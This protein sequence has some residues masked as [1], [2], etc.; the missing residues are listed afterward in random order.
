MDKKK[1]TPWFISLSL[2]IRIIAIIVAFWDFNY[3]QGAVYQ[4]DA[5]ESI[6]LTIALAGFSIRKAAKKILGNYF[7]NGINS[8]RNHKL[9]KH[10]I[11]GHIR[12][13]IY[14]GAILLNL[15]AIL[16]FSSLPGFIVMLGCV[17]CILYR[18]RFEE[19]M[20]IEKFGEE[21]RDYM[22]KT[23]KIIPFIY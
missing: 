1:M 5:L 12:H 8:L 14:L 17:P 3:V 10:G 19:K 15:G 4:F 13:P 11:Y 21:Y 22:K 7:L 18:I 6:G 9:V 23:K 16:L 20:L 2:L